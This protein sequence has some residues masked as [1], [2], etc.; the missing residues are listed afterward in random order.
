[1]DKIADVRACITLQ[2]L[3]SSL[4]KLLLLKKKGLDPPH[5]IITGHLQ[6]FHSY[7]KSLRDLVNQFT[8][9]ESPKAF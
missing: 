2:G 5:Q 3:P 6:K 8:S 9:F 7:L 1:M 4:N